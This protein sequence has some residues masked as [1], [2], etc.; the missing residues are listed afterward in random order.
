LAD[1]SPKGLRLRKV[2]PPSLSDY[3][4][5]ASDSYLGKLYAYTEKAANVFAQS[6][7]PNTSLRQAGKDFPKR[8]DWDDFLA[9]SKDET[10]EPVLPAE[11]DA[12]RIALNPKALPEFRKDNGTSINVRMPQP[13]KLLKKMPEDF[14]K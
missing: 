9:W 6:F 4:Y 1:I 10:R 11:D 7:E 5:T 14:Q 2:Y 8:L 13:E 12:D 3:L